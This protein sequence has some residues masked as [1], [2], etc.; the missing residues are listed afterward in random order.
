MKNIKK[1][2]EFNWFGTSKSEYPHH[3]DLANIKNREESKCVEFGSRED[4]WRKHFSEFYFT[5][6]ECKKISLYLGDHNYMKGGRNSFQLKVNK[7]IG[8]GLSDE[9]RKTM[10]FYCKKYKG[11][12]GD[13]L[14]LEYDFDGEER[15]FDCGNLYSIFSKIDELKNEVE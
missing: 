8:F 4:F 1:F 7:N 2:E 9:T 3:K 10:K 14:F 15:F 12:D 11:S 5:P 13:H 6:E